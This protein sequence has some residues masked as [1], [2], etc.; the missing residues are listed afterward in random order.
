MADIRNLVRNTTPEKKLVPALVT[1][2]RTETNQIQVEPNIWDR[3]LTD[4]FLRGRIDNAVYEERQEVKAEFEARRQDLIVRREN[5]R[6]ELLLSED[7]SPYLRI[8]MLDE[9]E[10]NG[11]ITNV[12][13]CKLYLL[14]PPDGHEAGILW[15]KVIQNSGREQEFWF[16]LE[17]FTPNYCKRKMCAAGITMTCT[18]Q[19]TRTLQERLMVLLRNKATRVTIYRCRG[20]SKTLDGKM[21]YIDENTMIWKEALKNA[22]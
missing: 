17:N 19:K 21:V 10:L 4:R 11:K 22:E 15:G 6:E 5:R 20:W 3:S 2:E 1:E 16:D 13:F 8:S 12:R 18:P 9:P 14:Q 7:G